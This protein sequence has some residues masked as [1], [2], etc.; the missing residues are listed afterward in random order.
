MTFYDQIMKYED[1][2]GI[3]TSAGNMQTKRANH[4]VLTIDLRHK[5]IC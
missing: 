1:E 4:A 3:W 5:T 2:K